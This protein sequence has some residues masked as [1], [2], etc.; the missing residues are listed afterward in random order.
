MRVEKSASKE[1]RVEECEYRW[2]AS[3]ERESR[4][5]VRVERSVA[6]RERQRERERERVEKE[7]E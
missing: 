1:E 4:E 6:R 7:G 2:S 3:R 5:G